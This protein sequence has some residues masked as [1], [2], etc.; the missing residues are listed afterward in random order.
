MQDI[1]KNLTDISEMGFFKG[2]DKVKG[3]TIKRISGDER[4]H[5][6]LIEF[7]DGT[8]LRVAS[9]NRQQFLFFSWEKEK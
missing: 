4:L 5:L 1:F 2:M 9:E 7:T 6:F 8:I 3:K